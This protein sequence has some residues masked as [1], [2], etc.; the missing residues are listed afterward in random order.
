MS[1]KPKTIKNLPKTI[2][3]PQKDKH[4]KIGLITLNNNLKSKRNKH[5][6][7]KNKRH[8]FNSAENMY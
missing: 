1:Y 2:L 4:L 6:I 5:R 7:N 3:N 8:L